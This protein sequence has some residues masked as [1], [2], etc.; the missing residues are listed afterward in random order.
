MFAVVVFALIFQGMNHS[1]GVP[2]TGRLTVT[3]I[4][5]SSSTIVF[6]PD[7]TTRVIIANAPA[8][9]AGLIA[10]MAQ[11]PGPW[12]RHKRNESRLTK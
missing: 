10:A 1:P 9:Q 3:A 6:Q 2:A 8:D 7:G 12:K 4:V 11:K 5:T